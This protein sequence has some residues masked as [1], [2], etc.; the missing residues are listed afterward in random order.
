MLSSFASI[1][2]AKV[3]K[4]VKSFSTA[5]SV[6][7]GG[8]SFDPG[9]T[10]LMPSA[11]LVD[12]NSEL[13]VIFGQ[14][15]MLTRRY[16]LEEKVTVSSSEKGTVMRLSDTV[17]FALGKAEVLPEAIPFLKKICAIINKTSGDIRIE[18]HTDDLP[19]HTQRYPSNWELSTARAV[20]CLRYFVEKGK[21]SPQRVSAAGFGEFQPIAPNDN[22]ENRARNR[23]VEIVFVEANQK[24][25]G[26]I[27]K[28]E[29]A[30]KERS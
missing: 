14:I 1:E 28:S 10:V 20:N 2:N 6:L 15:E 3:M 29:K 8:L 25:P 27:K 22:H 24:Y 11:G 7:S 4:F 21:I 12:A 19:I 26:E 13:A 30:E 9:K 18:G 23:R 17:L 5:L 16:G